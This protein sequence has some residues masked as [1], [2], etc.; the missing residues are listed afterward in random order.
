MAYTEAVAEE[1]YRLYLKSNDRCPFVKLQIEGRTTEFLVDTAAKVTAL[2]WRQI[3][4]W[5]IEDR[6]RVDEETGECKIHVE[7]DLF[8][9]LS[10]SVSVEDLDLNG[11][12][13]D[14]L[15][16]LRCDVDLVA[17]ILTLRR[18]TN[19]EEIRIRYIAEIFNVNGHELEVI[20]DT[21][22]NY[23]CDMNE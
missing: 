19:H 11:L 6:V 17:G 7:F 8:E 13:L 3:R 1:K 16:A 15:Q 5:G 2:S 14:F 20:V 18:I 10:N 12:G 22:T 21:G 9:G 4:E 23:F